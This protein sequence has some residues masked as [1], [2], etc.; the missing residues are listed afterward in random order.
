MEAHERGYELVQSSVSEVRTIDNKT[1]GL[2]G[3]FGEPEF[4]FVG[5]GV[6]IAAAVG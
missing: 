6:G 5:G 4:E 1:G 2:D 3:S